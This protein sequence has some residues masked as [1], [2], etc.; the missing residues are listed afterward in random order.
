MKLY[1]AIFSPLW[2][3]IQKEDLGADYAEDTINSM[4]NCE[5]IRAISDALDELEKEKGI[6]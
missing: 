6:I 1:L 3:K 4:T 2:A 5:L